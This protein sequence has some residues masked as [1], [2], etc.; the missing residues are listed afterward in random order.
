[1]KRNLNAGAQQSLRDSLILEA[2]AM[3]SGDPAESGEAI[4]AFREKRQPNF[5]T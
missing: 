1:M 4:R 2:Q 3:M 5:H